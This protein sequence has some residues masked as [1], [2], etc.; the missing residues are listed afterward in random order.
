MPHN[1]RSPHATTQPPLSTTREKPSRQ[2]R[3]GAAKQINKTETTLRLRV[4]SSQFPQWHHLQNYKAA[5]QA[6]YWHGGS[7][8]AEMPISTRVP[9]LP[10]TPPTLHPP[11]PQQ[12]LVSSP[13]LWIWCC[14]SWMLR[15][16]DQTAYNL[17]GLDFFHSAQLSADPP[18][19]LYLVPVY[20]WAVIPDTE[21]PQFLFNHPATEGHLVFG[22]QKDT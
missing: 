19:L 10:C 2:R 1:K 14:I 3:P 18:K 11:S 4:P 13:F 21:T 7:Q 5:S 17:L 16:W 6:G 8:D 22:Y 9:V 12:P 20:C 15:Q